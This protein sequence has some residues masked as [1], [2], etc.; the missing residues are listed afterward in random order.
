M[1]RVPSK[2]SVSG[3]SV[4]GVAQAVSRIVVLML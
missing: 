2:R 1:S 4:S 3:A